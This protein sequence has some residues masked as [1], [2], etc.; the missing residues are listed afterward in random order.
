MQLTSNYFKNVASNGVL[1][2]ESH[3]SS[4]ASDIFEIWYDEW[5]NA[6]A[7]K[8]KYFTNLH[9]EREQAA[10]TKLIFMNM[11]NYRPKKVPQYDKLQATKNT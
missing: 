4:V 1:S 3:A 6:E 10:M 8:R 7:D 2:T 5:I 9:T 11:L